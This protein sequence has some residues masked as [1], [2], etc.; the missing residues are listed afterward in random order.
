MA[1]SSI[2]S[3]I[4]RDIDRKSRLFHTLPA[5][6]AH[7]RGPRGNIAIA[8]GTEKLEWLGNQTVKIV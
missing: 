2:I 1:L 6:D 4:K 3:E 7:V 8:F 5:F